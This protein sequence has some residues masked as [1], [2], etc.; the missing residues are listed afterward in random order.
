MKIPS[1]FSYIFPNQIWNVANNKNEIYLTFDDGPIPEITPWVL[2]VLKEY[3]VSATFFCI[4]DNI[5][6][7]PEIFKRILAEGHQIGNH[8]FNHLNGWKT[9]TADYTKNI[10]ACAAEIAKHTSLDSRLLRPPYGRITSA[11]IKELQKENYRIIMWEMLSRDYDTALDQDKCY[12]NATKKVRSGSI[13]VFHDSLKA[14]DRLRYAL[15]KTIAF[16]LAKGFK[17]GK[18]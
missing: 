10:T 3:H 2:D 17:F 6:K 16:L 15:P 8:T 9:S 5:R 7:H 4:G 12:Q 14:E 18:L 13:I 1:F 11:Q